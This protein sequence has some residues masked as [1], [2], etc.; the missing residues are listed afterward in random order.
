MKRISFILALILCCLGVSSCVYKSEGVPE[1]RV[2]MTAR[3]DNI[4]EYIEVTVLESEYTFGPHWV[5]T[6]ENTRYFDSDGGQISRAD[7]AAG[8]TVEILYSGQVMLSYPP[9]IVAAKI[10]KI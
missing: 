9:K 1:G 7:L 8:D 10:T 6:A 4:S 2:K 3:I 5:I